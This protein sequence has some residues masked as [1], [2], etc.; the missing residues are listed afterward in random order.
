MEAISRELYL[1]LQKEVDHRS[2]LKT[3][4]H[5]Q[6][7]WPREEHF[8]LNT[9]TVLVWL[10]V[11]KFSGKTD[12]YGSF[13]FSYSV[14]L[15][16]KFIHNLLRTMSRKQMSQTQLHV[17]TDIA[18][19]YQ[20]KSKSCKNYAGLNILIAYQS[21]CLINFHQS[22]K[23]NYGPFFTKCQT[24]NTNLLC[25]LIFMNIRSCTN[26]ASPANSSGVQDQMAC[27]C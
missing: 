22:R 1:F 12:V 16:A 17:S 24:F 6:Q 18:K 11:G 26:L 2:F 14:Q 19:C 7:K 3:R 13:A 21:E 15:E 20:T 9:T 5:L 10:V 25:F 8:S 27:T 4:L 23:K